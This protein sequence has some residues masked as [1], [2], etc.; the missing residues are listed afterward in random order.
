MRRRGTWADRSRASNSSE[1]E[2]RA[3][4][5][6]D[7]GGQRDLAC[8]RQAELLGWLEAWSAW[9]DRAAA[10]SVQ[11]A[12][13]AM[14]MA[15]TEAASSRNI[16]KHGAV[17]GA[18]PQSLRRAGRIPHL[19]RRLP[20]RRIACHGDRARGD[21]LPQSHTRNA[22]LS[23]ELLRNPRR[24]GRLVVTDRGLVVTDLPRSRSTSRARQDAAMPATSSRSQRGTAMSMPGAARSLS[25]G[26][27]ALQFGLSPGPPWRVGQPRRH[28]R[29]GCHPGDLRVS[30]ASCRTRSHAARRAATAAPRS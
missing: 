13:R 30:K 3:G 22:T 1:T 7:R 15:I 28:L 19:R 25:L 4:P 26:K 29:L 11:S 17:R 8:S 2:S 18:R 6:D 20:R 23:S 21:R 9:L 10:S 12:R 27:G 5:G 24:S 16:A 14:V